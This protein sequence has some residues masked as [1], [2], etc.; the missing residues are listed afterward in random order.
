MPFKCKLTNPE[1]T[2]STTFFIASS[3]LSYL[4]SHYHPHPTPEHAPPLGFCEYN[5]LSFCGS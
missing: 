4:L 1:P 3:H 2:P 5:K